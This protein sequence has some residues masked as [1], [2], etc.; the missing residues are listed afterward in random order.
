MLILDEFDLILL[1]FVLLEVFSDLLGR[2][3]F[4]SVVNVDDVI[5]CV[6]LLKDR[7]QVLDVI[8]GVFE[9]WNDKAEWQLLD[10]IVVG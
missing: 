3:I 8:V 10:R 9:A 4:W 5:V 2:P 1:D 6:G 7:I